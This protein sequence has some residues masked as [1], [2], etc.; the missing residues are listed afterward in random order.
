MYITHVSLYH[1]QLG[2][3]LIVYRSLESWDRIKHNHICWC[4][5]TASRSVDLGLDAMPDT[6]LDHNVTTKIYSDKIYIVDN[7]YTPVVVLDFIERVLL[8]LGDQIYDFLAK[9]QVSKYKFTNYLIE[10]ESGS[11]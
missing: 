8:D 2:N 6:K 3:T 5:D 10:T 7:I 9:P 4:F 11:Y 1:Y